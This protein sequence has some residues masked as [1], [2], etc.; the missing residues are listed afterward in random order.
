MEHCT[1]LKH[2]PELIKICPANKRNI[3][4]CIWYEIIYFLLPEFNWDGLLL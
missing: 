3:L 4:W 2:F 1:Q